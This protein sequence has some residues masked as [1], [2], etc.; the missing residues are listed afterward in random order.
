MLRWNGVTWYSKPAVAIVVFVLLIALLIYINANTIYKFIIPDKLADPNNLVYEFIKENGIEKTQAFVSAHAIYDPPS[1]P[2]S[3]P[4]PIPDGI[5]AD[6]PPWVAA[7]IDAELAKQPKPQKTDWQ[8]HIGSEFMWV[9]GGLVSSHGS[10]GMYTKE[11]AIAATLAVGLWTTRSGVESEL[12]TVE[13]IQL[14]PASAVGGG[15][16]AWTLN[17]YDFHE[18]AVYCPATDAI[19]FSVLKVRFEMS[20]FYGGIDIQTKCVQFT[21]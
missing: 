11:D 5:M 18:S 2:P 12:P 9:K 3:K 8:K 13:S 15:G 16:N 7:Q 1:P 20:E 10:G 14:V 17:A 19:H 6:A 4:Q 21:K